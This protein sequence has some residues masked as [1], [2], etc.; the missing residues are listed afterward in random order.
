MIVNTD[1][2]SGMNIC[3]KQT[4]TSPKDWAN[5]K[6]AQIDIYSTDLQ[7]KSD[8]WNKESAI[9]MHLQ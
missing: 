9:C 8:H 7:E 5:T 4:L 6:E 2:N 3:A 1:M